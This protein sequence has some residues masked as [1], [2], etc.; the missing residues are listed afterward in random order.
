MS[1][2]FS[3]DAD[4]GPGP[5]FENNDSTVTENLAPL[6]LEEMTG[7]LE[8]AQRVTASFD[9]LYSHKNPQADPHQ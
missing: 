7:E 8:S 4:A 9:T 6:S 5:H 1:N 2:K 3:S